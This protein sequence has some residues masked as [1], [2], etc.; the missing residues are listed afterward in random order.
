MTAR[1]GMS[2]R[3]GYLNVTLINGSMVMIEPRER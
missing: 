3:G 2:S 1:R